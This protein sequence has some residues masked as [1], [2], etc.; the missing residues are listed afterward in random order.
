MLIVED[1]T[2]KPDAE[3]YASV[4]QCQAYA[5]GHGLDFSGDDSVL[6]AA[7][8]NAALYLDGEY[9]FKGSRL[10]GAQAL[11]WPRTAAQGVPREVVNACCELAVRAKLRPLWRD[12][13]STTI[14]AAVEKTVGPITTKYASATGARADGQTEYA[15]VT[16]ML[17][18]WLSSYGSSVKLVRS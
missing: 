12:V 16:A 5:A 3:S 4:A 14:G 10:T 15:G 13:S 18:R 7:L 2:G 6:E 11:E 8:R 1:G 17:R 9:T